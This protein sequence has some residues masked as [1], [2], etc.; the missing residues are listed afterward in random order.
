MKPA[1]S[2]STDVSFTD[3][4]LKRQPDGM[5]SIVWAPVRR[6]CAAS[7]VDYLRVRNSD[8][9]VL[10]ALV[11]GWYKVHREN[12]GSVNEVAEELLGEV[13]VEES[14]DGGFIFPPGHA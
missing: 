11:V 5:M 3:L 2:N 14:L 9:S 7:G 10:I 6:L 4:E 8:E 1:Q 13:R 12:G